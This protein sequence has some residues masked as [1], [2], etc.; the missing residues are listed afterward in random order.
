MTAIKIRHYIRNPGY[1]SK[2]GLGNIISGD[3]AL[4]IV[5]RDD[6]KIKLVPILLECD[7]YH[8]NLSIRNQENHTA[9]D[10]AMQCKSYK[11]IEL[12]EKEYRHQ[13][14]KYLL[15]LWVV[16]KKNTINK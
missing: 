14:Y 3:T 9:L 4:H 11:I 15:S 12:I 7:H 6:W 8:P 1:Y 2:R 5:V 10:I 13:I 16:S